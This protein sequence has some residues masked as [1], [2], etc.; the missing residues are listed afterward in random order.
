MVEARSL[1]SLGTMSIAEAWSACRG[2]SICLANLGGSCLHSGG[3]W[4]PGVASHHARRD[5]K[6]AKHLPLTIPI[7]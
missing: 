1:H 2:G 4:H 3:L 7:L 5:L 6:K